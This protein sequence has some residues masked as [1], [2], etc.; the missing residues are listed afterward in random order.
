MHIEHKPGRRVFVDFAGDR[1]VLTDASGRERTVQL[2]VAVYPAGGLI[3]AEATENQKIAAR[4]STPGRTW[5]AASSVSVG[6][7]EMSAS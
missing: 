5:I 4:S 2:F 1:P 3:Y 6:N 7:A